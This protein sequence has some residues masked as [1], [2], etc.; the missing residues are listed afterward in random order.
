[1]SNRQARLAWALERL[2]DLSG[3]YLTVTY[4][5]DVITTNSATLGGYRDKSRD[6]PWYH[7]IQEWVCR[8]VGKGC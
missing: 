3:N 7:S 6:T 1:M 2:A 8:T 4:A 5:F